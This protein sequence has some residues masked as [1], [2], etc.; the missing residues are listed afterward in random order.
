MRGLQRL[1]LGL[2]FLGAACNQNRVKA[3]DL[4]NEAE[5]LHQRNLNPQAVDRL[6]EAIRIDPECDVCH[7]N[8]AIIYQA[9]EAWSDAATHFKA[10]ADLTG[11]AMPYAN[12]GYVLLKEAL[13]LSGSKEPGDRDKVGE[14]LKEAEDALNR[15][16]KADAE[17]Y[18][19]YYYLGQVY[20]EQDRFEDAAKM[21]RTCIDKNAKFPESFNEYGKVFSELDMLDKAEAVFREG[22]R[23]NAESGLLHNQL[24]YT[25]KETARYTEAIEQFSQ[26]IKDKDVPEA[27]FNLGI[28]YYE[29]GGTQE[30]KNA[31]YYLDAFLKSGSQNDAMKAQA[32]IVLNDLQQEAA[33]NR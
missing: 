26:A 32:R 21:F 7:Q 24:G 33:N 20:R 4:A 25:L 1:A 16:I 23:V 13:R 11:E 12:L 5:Q 6:K 8:L 10:A 17:L 29:Q 30:K 19:S 14:R 15:A 27:Y 22:L 18:L 3:I 28:A 2:L 31:E 9:T